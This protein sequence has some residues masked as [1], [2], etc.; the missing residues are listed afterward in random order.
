[1]PIE[2]GSGKTIDLF[3]RVFLHFD[4]S[5]EATS[6]FVNLNSLETN[7]ESFADFKPFEIGYVFLLTNDNAVFTSLAPCFY[8]RN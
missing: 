2:I 6:S 4:E 3:V 1:M 5:I 8:Y 7:S